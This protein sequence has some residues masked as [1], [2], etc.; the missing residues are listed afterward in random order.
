MGIEVGG[1]H[2]L[3]EFVLA[4]Y[5]MFA[6]VYFHAVRRAFD[7]VLTEFIGDLLS[8]DD[9]PGTYPGP[10]NGNEYLLW[11]DQRVIAAASVMRD[12]DAK[13]LAWRIIDRQHPKA[14]YETGSSP[15]K[16]I[17]RKVVTQLLDAA[18]EEFPDTR[19]WLDQAVDH[20]DKFRVEN[21]MI[22]QLGSP[23]NWRSFES[24]SKALGALTDVN[25][26]RIYADVRGDQDMEDKV[27][28]FCRDFMK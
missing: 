2:A 26:V 9:G 10:E 27:G 22:K 3:E 8:Q 13:N 18:R 25:Q 7:L 12:S 28:L 24:E 17:L 21:I 14:I 16:G 6:Q 19:F 20:P 4:R 1:Q 5:F 15:D 11:D 23:S